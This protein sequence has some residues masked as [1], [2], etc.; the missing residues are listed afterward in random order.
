MKL[1]PHWHVLHELWINVTIRWP[2]VPVVCP[3]GPTNPTSPD[4]CPPI[5]PTHASRHHNWYFLKYL[6]AFKSIALVYSQRNF[7]HA[8]TAQL[9]W[10]VHNFFVNK[11]VPTDRHQQKIPWVLRYKLNDLERNRLLFY[12]SEPGYTQQLL[13]LN[14]QTKTGAGMLQGVNYYKCNR[15]PHMQNFS[16]AWLSSL[17]FFTCLTIKCKILYFPRL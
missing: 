17:K 7:A 1:S 9:S 4:L 13:P 14:V 15:A 5:H 16:L 12:G 6:L 10:H 8:T 11:P 2:N 3:S